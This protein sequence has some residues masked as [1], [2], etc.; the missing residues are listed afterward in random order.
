MNAQRT[1][2]AQL[3]QKDAP[4]YFGEFFCHREFPGQGLPDL[5]YA[6]RRIPDLPAAP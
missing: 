5:A 4:F 1:G 3:Q 2:I 6:I